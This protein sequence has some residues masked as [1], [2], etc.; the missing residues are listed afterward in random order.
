MTGKTLRLRADDLH[1]REVD[2]ELIALDLRESEYFA[3]NRSGAALWAAIAAGASE[4]ELA[5]LLVERF[6]LTEEA[7]AADAQEFVADLERRGLV[8]HDQ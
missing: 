5:D 6:G 1:W 8:T 2:G 4:R 3:V 7:A